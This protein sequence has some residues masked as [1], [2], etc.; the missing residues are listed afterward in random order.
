MAGKARHFYPGGNTSVGFYSFFDSVFQGVERKI[1]FK[2]GPGTGKSTCFKK[3]GEQLLR[4]GL[5]VE[6]LHCPSDNDS[7]DGIIVPAL[8]TGLVDG[9]SP[10][11]IDPVYPGVVDEIVN[12]GEF[13]DR[14]QLLKFKDEIISLTDQNSA[15][16]KEAYGRFALAK[17]MHS[18]LEQCYIEGM[19]FQLADYI[20]ETVIGEIFASAAPTGGKGRERHM[21]MGAATPEGPRHFYDNLTEGLRTRY[22]VKGRPGTGKS[23][24]MK[25][26]CPCRAGKRIR[27]R[28]VSLCIRSRIRRYGADPQAFRGHPGWHRTP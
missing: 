9:T 20:A 25:K 1:I 14:K 15:C 18:D 5:D 22:I 23:T 6:F 19:N 28:A 12:L 17:E 8:K 4:Q 27:C 26:N 16:Y 3:I 7:L 21:F 13:W 11:T 24:L 10:H 2:G